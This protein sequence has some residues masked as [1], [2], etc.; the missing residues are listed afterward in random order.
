MFNASYIPRGNFWLSFNDVL[1]N[2]ASLSMALNDKQDDLLI[3]KIVE[4]TKYRLEELQKL[5]NQCSQTRQEKVSETSRVGIRGVSMDGFTID[6][7]PQ[8]TNEH[9]MDGHNA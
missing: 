8:R 3:K 9:Q 1:H 2:V 6:E 7:Y 5:Y 4:N